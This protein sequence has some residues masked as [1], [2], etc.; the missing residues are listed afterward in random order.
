[1]VSKQIIDENLA[2]RRSHRQQPFERVGT[3][4]N[5][6]LVD[7]MPPSGE[8]SGEYQDMPCVANKEFKVRCDIVFKSDGSVDGSGSS[9][10]G[11]FMIKGIYNLYSGIVAWRQVISSSSSCTENGS[12][13]AAEFYGELSRLQ[14]ATEITGTFLTNKGRYCVM[15]L[16]SA[17]ELQTAIANARSIDLLPTPFKGSMTPVRDGVSTPS[18][19]D[20][21][22]QVEAVSVAE[23][24]SS[25]RV[26]FS[27]MDSEM[28]TQAAFE[29]ETPG[30]FQEVL[31]SVDS[32]M[33]LQVAHEFEE[34]SGKQGASSVA[35]ESTMVETACTRE[36][37]F[38]MDCESTSRRKE[39]AAM[40]AAFAVLDSAPEEGEC[41]RMC[42]EA[43]MEAAFAVLD[44]APEE[45]ECSVMCREATREAAFAVL[46]SAPQEEEEV[47]SI[48][49]MPS[50]VDS[51]VEAAFAVFE[52]SDFE[53]S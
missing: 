45:D 34:G 53:E 23:E 48:Q 35:L 43:T 27:G 17:S 18:T 44:S 21:E 49:Q 41:S 4:E 14:D 50:A 7:I 10:E 15:K 52:D 47:D 11:N 22:T 39:Q 9:V 40:E 19:V 12:R 16:S 24:A 3:D 13:I 2:N 38:G 36:M 30:G 25:A 8:W 33:Q 42:H 6:A 26:V 1:M 32:R 29:V 5:E 37:S 51:R 31:A 20:S 46:D 28:Q